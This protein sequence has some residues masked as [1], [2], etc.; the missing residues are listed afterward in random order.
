MIKEVEVKTYI[1]RLYC[2]D[3]GEEMVSTGELM[4]SLP[5]QLKYRCP[6]CGR[7]ECMTDAYPKTVYKEVEL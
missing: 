3:C 4:F 6:K 5:L 7:E 1:N 2:D